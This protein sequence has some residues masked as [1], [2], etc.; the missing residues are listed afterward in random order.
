MTKFL[1]V[2]AFLLASNVFSNDRVLAAIVVQ[3]QDVTIAAGER[4]FMNVLI[5]GSGDSIAAFDFEFEISPIGTP[6]SSMIFVD[7]QPDPQLNDPLFSSDYVFAGNSDNIDNSFPMGF[8]VAGTTFFGSDLTADLSDVSISASR[9]FVRF[10]L[11]SVVP[12][13]GVAVGDQFEIRLVDA[14]FFDSNFDAVS[15]SSTPGI[16]TV[17]AVAI[18]EPS[19][20]I[21]LMIFAGCTV[22]W[23]YRG[24]VFERLVFL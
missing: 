13:G 17:S 1:C 4:G 22:V 18:P 3:L 14:N 11:E 10:E 24:C 12:G 20:A 8:V 5:S 19:S 21:V 2:L 23:R 7:P 15:F 16:V 6:G 9:L